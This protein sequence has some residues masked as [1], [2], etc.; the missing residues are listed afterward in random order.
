[1]VVKALFVA[2]LPALAYVA[3]AAVGALA[4]DR[5]PTPSRSR[6]ATTAALA[7]ATAVGLVVALADVSSLAVVVIP[8][9]A[10]LAW[11]L[12][13]ART[14]G[15]GSGGPTRRRWSSPRRSP[16][17]RRYG[18]VVDRGGVVRSA[19]FER[20]NGACLFIKV[21]SRKRRGSTPPKPQS[22]GPRTLAALL[23]TRFARSCGAYVTCAGLATA[24]SS[25][26]QHGTSRL[27]SLAA[28]ASRLRRSR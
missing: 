8:A 20:V 9:A 14:S 12:V 11:P 3:A 6:A 1:M 19:R 5:V 23:V 15:S 27:P 21:Y 17:A 22:R 25:P 2:A 7:G 13:G 24:P 26:T 16:S 18:R 28:H 10:V 4:P